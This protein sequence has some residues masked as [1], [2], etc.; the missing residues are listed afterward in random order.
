[1]DPL[2]TCRFCRSWEGAKVKYGVRHYAHPQCLLSGKGKQGKEFLLALP[3]WR[4]RN[5][6]ALFIKESG[7]EAEIKA[8]IAKAEAVR[9]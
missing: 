2:A 8:A 9:P 1:M 4:L 5:L 6:P 7:L 3:A